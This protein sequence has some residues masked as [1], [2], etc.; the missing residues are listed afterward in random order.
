MITP[1]TYWAILVTVYGAIIGSFLNMAIWRL[2]QRK[3]D[4]GLVRLLSYPGSH[5]PHC[6]R[7][8]R[9]FENIP[10]LSFI[11]LGGR[12]KGCKAPISWRYFW[13]ELV[14]LSLFLL[15]YL[16]FRNGPDTVAY[17]LF[18][19]ALV[20]AYVIDLDSFIIP[21]EV[22]TFALCVG[23]GRDLWGIAAHEPAHAPL[24]GWLPRSIFG[25]VICAGVF[26]LIQVMGAAL[27]KKDAMGDGDVKLARAIGAMLPLSQALVSFFLAIAIGA[28]WGVGKLILNARAEG[29]KVDGVVSNSVDATEEEDELAAQTSLPDILLYGLIYMGF[30]DLLVQLGASLRIPAAIR[31]ARGASG[32]EGEEPVAAEEDDFV[33]GP[34]HMPFGPSMVLGAFAAIFWGDALIQWYLHWARLAPPGS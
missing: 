8:L 11:M 4:V 24:W 1:E 31:L 20:A 14:T 17:C 9:A 22:N 26:V 12:C 33:A 16:H 34:T 27:F 28:V 2:P 18:G 7:A 13:V 23:V 6:N 32:P 29:S 21:E 25:A 19:A 10:L 15:L 3:P 5:C 30:I